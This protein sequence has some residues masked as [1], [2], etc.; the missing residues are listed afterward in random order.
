[1]EGREMPPPAYPLDS[2]TI[3]V[4]EKFTGGTKCS[5]LGFDSIFSAYVMSKAGRLLYSHL[6]SMGCRVALSTLNVDR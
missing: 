5:C 1:M 6:P 4:E 2:H 3:G